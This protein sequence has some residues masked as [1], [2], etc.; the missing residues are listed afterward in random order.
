[1]GYKVTVFPD[2]DVSYVT[3]CTIFGLILSIILF[4]KGRNPKYPNPGVRG[5]LLYDFWVG[6]E[7]NPRFGSLDIK[8]ALLQMSSAQV[9][10]NVILIYT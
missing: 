5:E 1:M 3:A 7:I 6:R 10:S 2:K 8:F 4:Y 9:V